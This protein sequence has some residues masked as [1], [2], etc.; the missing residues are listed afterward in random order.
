M[1]NKTLMR[2][3]GLGTV[4]AR[5]WLTGMDTGH[6]VP[7]HAQVVAAGEVRA[8]H[9][10]LFTMERRKTCRFSANAGTREVLASLGKT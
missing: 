10:S 3:A 9:R 5:L 8:W 6:R 2:T 7:S 1:R 4:G